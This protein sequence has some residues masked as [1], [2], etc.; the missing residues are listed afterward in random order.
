MKGQALRIG[1]VR[2]DV[3]DGASNPQGIAGT[4]GVTK[5]ATDSVSNPRGLA[6]TVS[7]IHVH[8]FTLC[9]ALLESALH[10]ARQGGNRPESDVLTGKRADF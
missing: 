2:A 9:I 5:A 3:I 10:P 8:M 4:C 6:L 7:I 1:W